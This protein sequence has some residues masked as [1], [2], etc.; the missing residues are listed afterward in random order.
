MNISELKRSSEHTEQVTGRRLELIQALSDTFRAMMWQGHKQGEGIMDRIGLTV[1]QAAVMGTLQ[2]YGG[3]GTMTDLA[4]RSYQSGGTVTGIVDRLV[5]AG[6]VERERD[7]EDR[8]VVYVRTTEAGTAKLEEIANERRRQLER[9]TMALTDE[10][11][12]QLSS[13]LSKLVAA[14]A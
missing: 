7:E 4:H 10:E 12:E 13:I 14:S 1:P 3:R 6:L 9:M 11:L 2:A 5:D 8:R